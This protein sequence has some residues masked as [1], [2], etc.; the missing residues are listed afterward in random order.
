MVFLR[1]QTLS[2]YIFFNEHI[3]HVHV[4]V[5]LEVDTDGL[6][7]VEVKPTGVKHVNNLR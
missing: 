1:V 4:H 7:V 6:K 3:A 5:M 2:L